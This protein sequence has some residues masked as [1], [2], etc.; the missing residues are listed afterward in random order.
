[1]AMAMFNVLLVQSDI[2]QGYSTLT[3]IQKS[4]ERADQPIIMYC[5]MEIIFYL[6]RCNKLSTLYV[7]P[8][9]GAQIQSLWCLLHTI[10]ILQHIELVCIWISLEHFRDIFQQIV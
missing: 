2:I 5:G 3:S 10:L 6:M 8:F 4:R 1:M 7:T 9:P